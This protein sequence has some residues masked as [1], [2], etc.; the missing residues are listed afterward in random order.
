M[1]ARI[2]WDIQPLTL[3]RVVRVA[4]ARHGRT[5]AEKVTEHRRFECYFESD[6][7]MNSFRILISAVEF[8]FSVRI[9]ALR[10]FLK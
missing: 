4:C 5:Y 8:V 3:V 10:N 9:L 2:E 1:V 6:G 7:N